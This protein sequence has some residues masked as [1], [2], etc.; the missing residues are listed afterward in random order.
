M[1]S[2]YRDILEPTQPG[3]QID[4]EFSKERENEGDDD[5]YESF[6]PDFSAED[7]ANYGAEHLSGLIC[8][9]NGSLQPLNL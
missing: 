7:K 5:K 9:T 6:D 1:V 2:R 3:P 4:E 8:T